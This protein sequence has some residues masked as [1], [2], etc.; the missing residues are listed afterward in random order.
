[1]EHRIFIFSEM[2]LIESVCCIEQIKHK[3]KQAPRKMKDAV[4]K[5]LDDVVTKNSYNYIEYFKG[6]KNIKK[7][8]S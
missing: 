3:I 8:N 6:A 4:S 7:L 5:K 1:M 2:P